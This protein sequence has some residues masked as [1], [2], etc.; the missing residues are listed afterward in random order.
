MGKR[1][2]VKQVLNEVCKLTGTDPG[3]YEQ[4][5]QRISQIFDIALAAPQGV[6]LVWREGVAGS[7]NIVTLGINTNDPVA[8]EN[9]AQILRSAA[10]T[11]SRQALAQ[12]LGE[13]TTN[14]GQRQTQSEGESNRATPGKAGR[15]NS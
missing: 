6:F 5:P 9:I 8:L 4:L 13:D 15:K 12:A 7:L 3:S 10:D 14:A 1:P 11:C 2:S